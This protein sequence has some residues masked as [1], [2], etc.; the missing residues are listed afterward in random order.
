MNTAY[1]TWRLHHHLSSTLFNKTLIFWFLDSNERT[2][3]VLCRSQINKVVDRVVFVFIFMLTA[4][5]PE[6]F[7]LSDSFCVI[8]RDQLKFFSILSR[9]C[10]KMAWPNSCARLYSI[11]FWWNQ[12]ADSVM[13]VGKDVLNPLERQLMEL[14]RVLVSRCLAFG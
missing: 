1:L 7:H 8:G 5:H 6:R 4:L 3:R 9:R 12:S 2:V 10:H 14:K 13:R 11:F